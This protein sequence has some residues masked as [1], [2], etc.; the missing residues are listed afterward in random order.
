MRPFT[1]PKPVSDINRLSGQ[2]AEAQEMLRGRDADISRLQKENDSLIETNLLLVVKLTNAKNQLA[3]V[4][5]TA[6]GEYAGKAA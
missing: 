6:R 5:R 1:R 3:L 2:L 4:G